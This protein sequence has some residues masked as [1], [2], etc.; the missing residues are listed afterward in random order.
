MIRALRLRELS[1][2]PL[3]TK[4][5]VQSNIANI[6]KHFYSPTLLSVIPLLPKRMNFS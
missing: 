1:L 6:S 2:F 3:L 5:G 4:G